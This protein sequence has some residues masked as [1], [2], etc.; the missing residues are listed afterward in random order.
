MTMITRQHP[1]YHKIDRQAFERGT[2][3]GGYLMQCENC[4]TG[5]RARRS[6]SRFCCGRCRVAAH[7]K[8]RQATIPQNV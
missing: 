3:Y 7:R 5:Y 6:T 4:D 1:D 2:N 8:L